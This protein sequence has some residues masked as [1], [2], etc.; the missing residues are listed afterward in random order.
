MWAQWKQKYFYGAREVDP[1]V[2]VWKT[3]KTLKRESYMD[4]LAL[5]DIKTKPLWLK[6]YGT[7]ALRDKPME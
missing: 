7:G 3:K 1:K 6:Q 2:Y 5:S 4:E